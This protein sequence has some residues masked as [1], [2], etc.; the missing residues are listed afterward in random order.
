MAGL[1][2]ECVDFILTDPPYLCRYRDRT[3]RT[4]ANDNNSHW[5]KPAFAE[6]YRVLRPDSLCVSFYGWNAA[7]Q[8]IEAWRAAGFRIVGHLVFSKS[9]AS[10]TRFVAA[11]H[12]SAYILAKGQPPLPTEAVPDVL[13]WQ[14]TGN[15]LHPTEKPVEPLRRLV[16]AFCPEG[17][18][19]LDPFC[20]SGSTLVAAQDCGR[21]WLGIE[22]DARHAETASGR[23]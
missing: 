21:N 2:A 1:P 18:L 4:V 12:E 23:V 8:F 15:R 17:G 3:G 14:Y 9:Y 20:G 22:L 13:P 7:D 16:K 10:S 5:L 6:A 11:H 19:V